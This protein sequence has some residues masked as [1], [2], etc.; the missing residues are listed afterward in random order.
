MKKTIL[1]STI[2]LS[3][4]FATVPMYSFPPISQ[5]MMVAKELG[6]KALTACAMYTVGKFLYEEAEFAAH[7]VRKV[8]YKLKGEV[9]PKKLRPVYLSR[10]DIKK[11]QL[12]LASVQDK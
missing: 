12:L 4:L 5:S 8:Y 9:S 3:I 7:E 2:G 11:L 10:Y 1:C 6:K